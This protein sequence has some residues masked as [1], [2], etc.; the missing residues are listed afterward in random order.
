[1]NR[2]M[3][4]RSS[5]EQSESTEAAWVAGTRG[6]AARRRPEHGVTR[7]ELADRIAVEYGVD[8]D[9]AAAGAEL[10]MRQLQRGYG[11]AGY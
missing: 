8:H 1:M 4:R 5:A 6:A 7:E 2:K 11:I 3:S 9:R 10:Y